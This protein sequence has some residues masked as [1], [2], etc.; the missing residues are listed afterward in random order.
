MRRAIHLLVP[1]LL[2]ALPGCKP[3]DRPGWEYMPDMAR[4]PAYD[5]FTP[6]PATR[7]GITLQRP[8]A[9]TIARGQ[10]PFHYAKGEPE[11]E[12]AGRELT[13]PY[14]ATPEVLERGKALYTIYCKVC[15]GE[16]G[17][18]DGPIV[19]KIPPPP[20][21]Q[22]TRVLGFAPGR[23]FHVITMGGS[24]MP[25]YAAQLSPDERWLVV[26]YVKNELQRPGA[27]PVGGQR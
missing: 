22:S 8:V 9:G 2:L 13:D 26:T 27:A 11:A 17:K 10:H 4:D 25:S 1:A 19:G 20:A 21:Y 7:D 23:I 15:H 18:G 14:T 3:G 24:K 16:R 6:N 5:A 12:R